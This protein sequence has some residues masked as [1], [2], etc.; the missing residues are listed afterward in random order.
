MARRQRRGLNHD[1]A[2]ARENE[3]T[4][5]ER[6]LR[7][8]ELDELRRQIQQLTERLECHESLDRDNSGHNSE[9]EH[10]PFYRR[11]PR[12]EPVKKE[13]LA[14]ELSTR[15]LPQNVPLQQVNRSVKEYTEEFDNL[16][17]R[18][19]IFEPEEQTI[20]RYLGGLRQEIQ[21]VVKLQHYWT[22]NDVYK[23]AINV[24][25]QQQ[26]RNCPN[27]KFVNLVE[28]VI[29]EEIQEERAPIFDEGDD[30][31]ITYSDQGEALVIRRSMN[32][33]LFSSILEVGKSFGQ[34]LPIEI[35]KLRRPVVCKH[36]DYTKEHQTIHSK[37]PLKDVGRVDGILGE[38]TGVGINTE[39]GLLMA[40]ILEDTGE[41]TPLQ[42]RLNG[43]ATFVGLF[44][45]LV[46]FVVLVVLLARYF[47]GHTKNPD[48]TIQFRKGKTHFQDAFITAAI[49]MVI[50]AVPE[51]LPLA[52]T[53]TLAYSTRKMMTDNALERAEAISVWV[54]MQF[55]D[56]IN[57]LFEMTVVEAYVGA[58]KIDPLENSTMLYPTVSALLIEGIAQNTTGNV[59]MPEVRKL[60]EITLCY[61]DSPCTQLLANES[62]SWLHIRSNSLPGGICRNGGGDMELAGSPTEKA[63]LSWGVKFG[64]KFNTVRSESSVLHVFPFNSEK[65]RG[66]VALRVW[67]RFMHLETD[68]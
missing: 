65:M 47:T 32:A 57:C 60:D 43:V 53:S 48:G 22:Y 62:A 55:Q 35:G 66:G 8:I 15:Y 25:R 6:D 39:W 19:G 31:D 37:A 18:C 13:I 14:R 20:A 52:V 1:E 64:M 21:D 58:N 30:G 56:H 59:F 44:G 50:F 40:N 4:G 49:T 42:V 24:E 11:A 29:E 51:G 12:R 16:M 3:A 68:V 2:P 33:S 34:G 27:R 41:E 63:I 9:D 46:S 28:E 38:V 26:K 54:V 5:R 23:L 7:D 61:K 17:V 45:I 67:I 36:P 10:N